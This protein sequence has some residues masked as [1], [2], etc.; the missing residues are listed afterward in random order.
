M[1]GVLGTFRTYKS[2][3]RSNNSNL[4]IILLYGKYFLFLWRDA[5]CRNST[6]NPPEQFFGPAIVIGGA[7]AKVDIVI[8]K[9]QEHDL[10]ND[11]SEEA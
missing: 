3:F 8:A 10:F 7:G 9:V 11:A 1:L 4:I 6:E 2:A 5:I